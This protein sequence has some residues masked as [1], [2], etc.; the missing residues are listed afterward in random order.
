MVAAYAVPGDSRS[1]GNA[2]ACADEFT[3]CRR[4]VAFKDDMGD[5]ACHAAVEVCDRTKACACFQRDEACLF[6][7]VQIDRWSLGMRIGIRHS[8]HDIFLQESDR[9]VILDRIDRR[10]KRE[11]D[12]RLIRLARLVMLLQDFEADIRMFLTET[13]E[14][15]R[16]DHGSSKKRDR[17]GQ[18]LCFLRVGQF[19]LCA[20]QF[21][22]D[23]VRVAEKDFTITREDDIA[24]ASGEKRHA[25]LGLEHFDRVGEGRL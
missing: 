21:L 19:L 4:A 12:V 22:H 23:A 6:E 15:S 3:D 20:V 9:M 8:Q 7:F 10:R 14:E 17:D 18:L 13:G 5:E 2:E 16:D 24:P 25:Q 11:V 1:E